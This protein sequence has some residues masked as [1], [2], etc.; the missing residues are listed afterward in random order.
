MLYRI[1]VGALSAILSVSVAHAQ[2]VDAALLEQG[3]QL[4][5]ETCSACHQ[6]TG[7][8]VPPTF[9]ALAGNA[10]L[11]DLSLIVTNIHNGKGAMP[12]F[13]D[14]D[15]NQ[16]AALATYIRNSWGN[17]FGGASA[18]EVAPVLEGLAS[19]APEGG[20]TGG[21]TQVSVWDGVYTEEQDVRG[22]AVHSAV[23]AKCHGTRGDGAGEPDQPSAPAI[24]RATFIRNWDGQSLAA[25]FEYV[26][27]TMPPDNP[28]SVDDQRYI[29]AV[30]H[31]LSLSNMPPGDTELTADPAA[32]ANIIIGPKPE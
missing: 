24:A 25:L 5:N 2:D 30:A 1:V 10:N 11:S 17:E 31:M 6:P 9:P 3:T 21:G 15:A 29:D 32:L 12:P 28:G 18:E 19:A 13:P 8:G 16:I 23:C 26:R 4:Y 14:F 20:E 7:V 22:K 27:T